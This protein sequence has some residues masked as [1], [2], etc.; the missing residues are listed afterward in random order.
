MDRAARNFHRGLEYRI[1]YDRLFTSGRTV[2]ESGQLFER[3]SLVLIFVS[4]S[5]RVSATVIP[6]DRDPGL[7]GPRSR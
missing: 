4:F 1:A 3:S 5:S 2:T 7:T 6:D